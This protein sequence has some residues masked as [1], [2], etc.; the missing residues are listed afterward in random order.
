MYLMEVPQDE[1]DRVLRHPLPTR[2][3]PYSHERIAALPPPGTSRLVSPYRGIVNVSSELTG[4]TLQVLDYRSSLSRDILTLKQNFA[5]EVETF[6]PHCL[7]VIGNTDELDTDA[8]RRAFELYRHQ[9]R[10]VE[11]VTFDEL[12][13]RLEHM[14]VALDTSPAPE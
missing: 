10:D 13:G 3:Y 6:H 12:F 14:L 4:A 2:S 1:I 7:V 5:V 11:V 9:L 8:K